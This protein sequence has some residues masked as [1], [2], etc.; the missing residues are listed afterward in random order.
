MNKRHCENYCLPRYDACGVV[1]CGVRG[2]CCLHRRIHHPFIRDSILLW[3]FVVCLPE[4]LST[5][6]SRQQSSHLMLWESEVT[7][8][9]FFLAETS[10]VTKE[11][12]SSCVVCF[13]YPFRRSCLWISGGIS[14]IL[15]ETILF[16]VHGTVHRDILTWI[17]LTRGEYALHRSRRTL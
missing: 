14:V 3:S 8:G 1:W 4:C 5:L 17:C 7:H 6:S 13:F 11:L 9:H 15:I 2:T 12:I 10:Y 16:D